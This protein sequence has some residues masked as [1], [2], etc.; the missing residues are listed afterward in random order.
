MTTLMG[1]CCCRSIP[2]V[3]SSGLGTAWKQPDLVPKGPAATQHV[4]GSLRGLARVDISGPFA[5]KHRNFLDTP[6]LDVAMMDFVVVNSA[7]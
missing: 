7:T 5:H 6:V 2:R 4:A 3:C 1:L